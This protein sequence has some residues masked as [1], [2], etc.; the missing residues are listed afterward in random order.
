MRCFMRLIS[1]NYAVNYATPDKLDV[2]AYLLSRKN[3]I[4][5]MACN[6]CYVNFIRHHRVCDVAALMSDK[7]TEGVVANNK[8]TGFTTHS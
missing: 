2:I 1:A 3:S 4:T 8:K 5:K 6:V 7:S